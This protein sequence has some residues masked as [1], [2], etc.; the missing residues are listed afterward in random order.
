MSHSTVLVVSDDYEAALVPFDESIEVE[1][2]VR[3]TRDDLIKRSRERVAQ[4]DE[5]RYRPYLAD[6]AGYADKYNNPN[7]I[8]FL[9]NEFPAQLEWADDEHYADMIRWESAEDIAPCGG[10]YSTYNPLS[11][12]DWY[13]VGGRWKGGLTTIAGESVNTCTRADLDVAN[14]SPTFALLV[15]GEWTERG[16]MGWFGL[17]SDEQPEDEWGAQWRTVVGALPGDARLTLVDVH[18]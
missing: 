5:H 1:R 15:D 16:H 9:R 8:E 13:A 12:W 6:P 7:H 14:T 3:H 17:V 11:R 2:Y 4:I 10:V 18:I